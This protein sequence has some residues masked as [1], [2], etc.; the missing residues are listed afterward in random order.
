[1]LS[2]VLVNI[3]L[4]IQRRERLRVAVLNWRILLQ[5]RIYH[6]VKRFFGD[7][8]VDSDMWLCV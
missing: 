4:T 6:V 3:E 7:S 2:R 5:K 8:S 1:M